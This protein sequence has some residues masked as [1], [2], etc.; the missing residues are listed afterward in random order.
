MQ[1]TAC[2]CP[3]GAYNSTMYAGNTIQCIPQSLHV[4]DIKASATCVPCDTAVGCARCA[5]TVVLLLP[6]WATSSATVGSDSAA[7]N[8]S[9]S[10]TSAWIF[11][12]PFP[13]ACNVGG[14]RCKTGHTGTLCAVCEVGY[15]LTSEE[16]VPC[17]SANSNLYAAAALAGVAA[18]GGL[19]IYLWLRQQ[20]QQEG[21][22]SDMGASL[23]MENPLQSSGHGSAAMS[24]GR[25][26][27][28]DRARAT[29]K[30]TG[31]LY[32]LL[33]VLYQPTRILVGYIQVRRRH[34]SPT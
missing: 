8:S 31:S 25:G 6:G 5:D 28:A 32:M 26:S 12:C 15:G 18:L 11:K 24:S 21:P 20:R 34:A 23:M 2:I 10:A 14:R 19:V 16:C 17:S 33:R 7:A 1:R 29:A 27:L 4:G 30:R 22:P 3:A 13:K 9:S